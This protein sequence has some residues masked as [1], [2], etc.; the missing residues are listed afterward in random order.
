[1]FFKVQFFPG[2]IDKTS[3]NRK[4]QCVRQRL[5]I[6]T[7]A[8]SEASKYPFCAIFNTTDGA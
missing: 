8:A 6:I 1:M 4:T 7:I 2:A 3:S 5:P